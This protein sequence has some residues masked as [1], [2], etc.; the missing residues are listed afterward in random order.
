ME[1]SIIYYIFL[2]LIFIYF[3]KY[4]FP[5]MNTIQMPDPVPVLASDPNDQA[6]EP[7][8]DEFYHHPVWSESERWSNPEFTD[9]G[10]ARWRGEPWYK[11]ETSSTAHRF[12]TRNAQNFCYPWGFII[13]RVVYTAESDRLWPLAMERLAYS[14]NLAIKDGSADR[15]GRPQQLVQTSHKDVILSDAA[16]WDGASI[17]QVRDHFAEYLRKTDQDVYPNEQRYALCFVIDEKALKSI[18]APGHRVGWV[19]AV[20][21][22][23]DPATKYEW[24]DYRGFMRVKV[25]SLWE[26]YLDLE[27]KHM[28]EVCPAPP[29]GWIPV[30][31]SGERVGQD[32]SGEVERDFSQQ[33]PAGVRP[34]QGRG[35][36]LPN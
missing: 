15:Q 11:S 8:E 25:R 24:P 19:G 36:G 26:L 18:T 13:Y 7:D 20:D 3:T 12:I 14:L 21:G 35:R 1:L 22:R 34:A 29:E 31:A 17:E 4:H 9:E 6:K 16:R 10:R 5:R 30:Y 2:L 33:R 27:G 28:W 23:F 32:E